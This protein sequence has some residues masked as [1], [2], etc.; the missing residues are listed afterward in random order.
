LTAQHALEPTALAVGIESAAAQR[1]SLGGPCRLR[2]V[3]EEKLLAVDQS[4]GV[5]D[6][7]SAMA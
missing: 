5:K 6:D 1:W 2:E 7:R 4:G 3:R